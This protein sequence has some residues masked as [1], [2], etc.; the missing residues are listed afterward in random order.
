[1]G[2]VWFLPRFSYAGGKGMVGLTRSCSTL[3]GRLSLPLVR[4]NY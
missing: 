2:L 3:K 1:L 4:L